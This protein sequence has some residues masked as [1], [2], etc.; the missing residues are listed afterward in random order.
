MNIEVRL[1]ELERRSMSGKLF[2]S[3]ALILPDGDGWRLKFSLW[4]GKIG[5]GGRDIISTH[6][7]LEDARGEY[8]RL[9]A[10]YRR[11]KQMEPVLIVW[12]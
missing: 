12:G 5:S 10:K 1:K 3:V 2:P 4:D 8:D 9:L 6:E 7:T 11:K